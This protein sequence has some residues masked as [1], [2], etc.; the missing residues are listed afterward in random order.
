MKQV[1]TRRNSE[2]VVRKHYLNL[3]T[4]EEADQFWNI[5]P[6]G[7]ALPKLKKK[8]GLFVE[9]PV[10]KKQTKKKAKCVRV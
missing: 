5:V 1:L 9:K 7:E 4:V 3:K 2:A 10:K 8:D 6:E